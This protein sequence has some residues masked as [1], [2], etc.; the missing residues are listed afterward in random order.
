MIHL[1]DWRTSKP[2]NYFYSL[3]LVYANFGCFTV[4]FYIAGCV[5]EALIEFGASIMTSAEVLFSRSQFS[6]A[7]G[8]DGN[9]SK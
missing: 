9:V 6:A 4:S 3:S 2:D 7:R 5:Y 8:R 1:F